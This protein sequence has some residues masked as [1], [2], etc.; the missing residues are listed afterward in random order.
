MEIKKILEKV[1]KM[2]NDAGSVTAGISR[3][4]SGMTGLLEGLKTGLSLV[5]LFGKKK[6]TDSS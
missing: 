2:L 3:S 5:S 6:K 1:N 4:F